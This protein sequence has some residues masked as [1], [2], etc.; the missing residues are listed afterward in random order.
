[1]ISLQQSCYIEIISVFSTASG[2]G[3]WVEGSGAPSAAAATRRRLRLASHASTSERELPLLFIR[4]EEAYC[5]LGG[6]KVI[7]PVTP[8]RSP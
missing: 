5:S 8:S 4:I 1:M 6:I 7:W 2:S 3:S